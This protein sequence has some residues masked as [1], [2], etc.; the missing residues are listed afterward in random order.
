[1]SAVTPTR[2]SKAPAPAT[3]GSLLRERGKICMGERGACRPAS[4]PLPHA[5]L[6]SLPQQA[7]AGRGCGRLARPRRRDGAHLVLLLALVHAGRVLAEAAGPV[8]APPPRRSA[9][10]RLPLLPRERR[11]R[12]AGDGASDGNLHEL[13]P[14]RSD[15]LEDARADPRELADGQGHGVGPHPQ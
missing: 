15:G 4:P 12:P 10:P 14:A 13:P 9:G 11:A 7:A 6:P 8:L 1:M 2:P 5:N 3:C